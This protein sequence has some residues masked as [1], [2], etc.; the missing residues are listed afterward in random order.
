MSITLFTSAIISKARLVARGFE[1]FTANIQKDSPT[2]AH[3]SLRL[4]IALTAQLQLGII[5]Y[6]ARA[7][8]MR[9]RSHPNLYA[10]MA[11]FSTFCSKGI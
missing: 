2:C 9:L 7:L 4:I 5:C 1:E 10:M 8:F 6:G 11:T 3:E